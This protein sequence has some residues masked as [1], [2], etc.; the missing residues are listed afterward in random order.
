MST[1]VVC[2]EFLNSMVWFTS[3]TKSPRSDSKRSTATTPPP[4]ASAAF[5]ES[6]ATSSV[7]GQFSA[8]PPRAVLVIQWALL[9]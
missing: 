7:R 3:L 9:R 4:T 6:R 1:P 8:C 5:T 2:T